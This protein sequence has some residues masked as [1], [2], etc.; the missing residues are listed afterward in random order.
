[1]P[2]LPL[3]SILSICEKPECNTNWSDLILALQR[4]H[5]RLVQ[6]GLMSEKVRFTFTF[7]T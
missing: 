7:V 6:M 1:M 3:L 4:N 2:I 5:Q